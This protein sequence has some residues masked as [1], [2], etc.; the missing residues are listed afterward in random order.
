MEGKGKTGKAGRGK[1]R[2]TAFSKQ[3]AATAHGG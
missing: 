3:I 2:D 1:G